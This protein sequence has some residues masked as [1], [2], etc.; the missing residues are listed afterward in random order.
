MGTVGLT[1]GRF[2]E[3]ADR[4][5]FIVVYPQGIGRNWNDGRK[6]LLNKSLSLET[7]DV[8]FL[9]EIVERLKK[10]YSIDSSRVFTSGMSNGGFMSTR[11]LCERADVFRGG[12]ILT[13]SISVD[14]VEECQPSRPVGVLV[15]NGTDDPIVPYRGGEI[16]LFKN[17]KSRGE[18]LSTDA[19]L[20][21]WQDKNSC[22][23]QD[24]PIKLPDLKA[25]GTS[26]IKINFSDCDPGG[27]LVL[28]KIEGGGHTWPGGK[29][30]LGEKIIGKTSRDI[31][32]CDV[33]WAFFQGL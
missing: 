32:A 5:G 27:A 12:A 6:V 19:Y 31:N 23:T 17:G 21:L 29:Q 26:I 28:Y 11:L 18:I 2:N 1:F 10:K 16:K 22:P 30:Y 7:D 24:A 20:E 13:A 15:M 4:D 8:G 3:L 14:Y 33:I 25:D 9:V